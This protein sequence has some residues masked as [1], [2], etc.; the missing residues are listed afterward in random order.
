MTLEMTFIWIVV[1]IFSAV[2]H[3]VAHGFVAYL[4]GDDTAKVAGRLTLNPISHIDWFGSVILPALLLLSGA[5]ILFAWAKP[6]PF[7][8]RK[9]K[10]PKVD[11]PLVSFAGPFSNIL[12]AVLAGLA[13]RFVM[14]FPY[15]FGSFVQSVFDVLLVMLSINIMLLI[16]NLIPIPPLDGSKVITYF[17]PEEIGYKYMSL[18]P[19]IGFILLYALLSTGVIGKIIGPVIA[20]LITFLSGIPTSF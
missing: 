8:P 19:L 2:I 20:F 13:I 7:D 17:M 9:L 16:I 11:I 6:V 1:L 18:N 14:A 15:L 4:R 3:E 5:K 12:L 10:N